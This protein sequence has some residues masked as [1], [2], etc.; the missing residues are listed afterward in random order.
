M[1]KLT[2]C[3]CTLTDKRGKQIRREHNGI[4]MF[5]LLIENKLLRNFRQIW[6]RVSIGNA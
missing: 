6:H 5:I 3:V 4:E 1:L 2:Q